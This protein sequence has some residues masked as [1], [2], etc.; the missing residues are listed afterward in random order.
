[1]KKKA[2]VLFNLGGPDKLEAVQPFL[3]NLFKDP[4]II[5]LPNPFR[6][7]L[8]KFISNRRCSKAKGIYSQIGGRSP[9]KELT[10]QQAIALENQLNQEDKDHEYKVFICMRYWHPLVSE[11]VKEVKAYSP[12]E[13]ILLPLYPQFS[14]STSGSSLKNWHDEMKVQNFQCETKVI[15][16]Y[17]TNTGFI[18][19]YVE[20]L[21]QQYNQALA[22]GK[23]R[24][25]FSAHGL[26]LKQIKAGDPYEAQV[27]KSVAAIVES[28]GIKDLDYLVTYQSKVGPLKWLEP[29]TDQEI[30]NACIAKQ[31]IV[32][33][34]IAFVSEHSETLVELDIEYRH[35][36]QQHNSVG[37]FRVPA[38]GV[39]SAFIE[40]LAQL[41]LN[42]DQ[43]L[44]PGV[45]EQQCEK[46]LAMCGC[47]G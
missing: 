35:L 25:L 5:S 41:C 36:A 2:V 45:N 14:A 37:Y 46:Q 42:A 33:V 24:V 40:G 3:Y 17:P 4:A 11:V 15:G 7:L 28:L 30:I 20:L 16:C 32:I 31:P 12:D 21:L 8:A 9:I 6:W 38:V 39:H 34:P 18:K 23:P 43:K 27:N 29:P 22:Y 19:A 1:M 44:A 13:L 10:E 47:R 26:P